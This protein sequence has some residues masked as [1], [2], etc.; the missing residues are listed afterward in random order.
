MV[1]NGAMLE[2]RRRRW[3]PSGGNIADPVNIE[4]QES[5]HEASFVRVPSGRETRCQ[6]LSSPLLG[7]GKRRVVQPADSCTNESRLDANRMESR[8]KYPCRYT[9]VCGH[10]PVDGGSVIS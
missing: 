5:V 7:N 10:P 4:H 8:S 1:Q 9:V 6:P 2:E 3:N